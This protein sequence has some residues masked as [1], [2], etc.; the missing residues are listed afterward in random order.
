[1]AAKKEET[2]SKL[3]FWSSEWHI[4]LPWSAFFDQELWDVIFNKL[5]KAPVKD[6]QVLL[7]LSKLWQMVNAI[8]HE[9]AKMRDEIAEKH[10]LK[11]YLDWTKQFTPET[12]N[13]PEYQKKSKEFSENLAKEI[14]DKTIDLAPLWPL[15]LDLTAPDG[16]AKS[17][18]E[19]AAIS[20]DD[21]VKLSDA[22]IINVV[23]PDDTLPAEEEPQ[24]AEDDVLVP[25][26]TD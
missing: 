12:M 1:M 19:W 26:T 6:Y 15:T 16:H 8:S 3:T 7:R 11:E 21:M 22:G 4:S 13:D 2:T 18:L 10:G 9:L 17:F 24:K 20:A 23:E 14:F 5:M 25:D